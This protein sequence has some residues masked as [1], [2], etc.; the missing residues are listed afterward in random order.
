[1]GGDVAPVTAAIRPSARVRGVTA[2]GP[3]HTSSGPPPGMRV[4]LRE[5]ARLAGTVMSYERGCSPD[6][7]GLFPVRLDNGIWQ[8]CHTSDVIVLT[9]ADAGRSVKAAHTDS[10]P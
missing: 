1:M 8:T 4:R 7:L 6:L 10:E 3:G 5:G 2:V 9:P